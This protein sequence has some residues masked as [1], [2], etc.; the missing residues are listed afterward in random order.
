MTG[1]GRIEI[2]NSQAAVYEEIEEA[3][4]EGTRALGDLTRIRQIGGKLFACGGLGQVYRRDPDGWHA[5]DEDLVHEGQILFNAPNAPGIDQAT[6]IRQRVERL[7]SLPN[8]N[9]IDGTAED[10]IYVCGLGG[11]LHHYTQ[12]WTRIASKTDRILTSLHV[13]SFD[14]VFVAGQDGV[15]LRGNSRDGFRHLGTFF[16][17]SY[18]WSIRKFRGEIYA[19]TL[20]GLYRIVGDEAILV[21]GDGLTETSPIIALDAVDNERMWVVS[22]RHAFLYDGSQVTQYRHQD[23]I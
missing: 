4:L 20:H 7:K 18:I 11:N 16:D 21:R 13:A 1:G 12:R 22:D 8:F 5:I 23:N 9:D 17:G 19:G 2:A 3:G 10:D 15:V 6:A 14:D